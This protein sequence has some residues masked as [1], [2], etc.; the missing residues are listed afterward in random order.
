M[1]DLGVLLSSRI[2]TMEIGG[3]TVFSVAEDY[4]IACFDSDVTD[5]IVTEIAQRRPYYAV[6]RDSS[7]ASDSVA[8]NFEQIFETYSP[9]TVRK[10]L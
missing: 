4:L 8:T 1:L 5:D 9:T 3:K 7:I 10:V 2:E 6:F